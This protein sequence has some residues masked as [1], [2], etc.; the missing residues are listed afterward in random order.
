[1][2]V[3]IYSNVDTDGSGIL[4][5]EE[6]VAFL[7][8]IGEWGTGDYTDET[9][10]E[11]WPKECEG[12]GCSPEGGVTWEAFETILYGKYR[13]SPQVVE[14]DLLHVREMMKVSV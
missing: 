10:D 13:T 3:E 4:R 2:I 9:F 12:M 8:S 11:Q 7:Q 14:D 6:Y 1:M 5:K